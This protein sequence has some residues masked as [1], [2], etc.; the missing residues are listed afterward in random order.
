MNTARYCVNKECTGCRACVEIAGDNFEMNNQNLAFVKKQAE[1]K[2]EEEQCLNALNICPVNAIIKNEI[3]AEID[4]EP[5]LA[6]SN[7]K[8]TLDKYPALKSVLIELSPKFKKMQNPALYNTLARF[9]SFSD[10][11]KI[12]GVSI[13]EILHTMNKF[14]G[15]E[16]KLL[17]SMPGCIVDNNDE[18]TGEEITWKESANRYIYD[19]S[20]VNILVGKITKLQAQE[21]IVVFSV[22]KPRELLRLLTVLKYRFN[23]EHSREYRISI[24]KDKEVKQIDWGDKKDDFEKIDVREA[25]DN[26][27]DGI[28]EKSKEMKEGEGFVLI[29][30]FEPLPMIKML[31]KDGFEHLSEKKSEDEVW[32]YFYKKN[33]M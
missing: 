12:T 5:I 1:N 15:V 23:I 10:A 6:K 29:Q 2:T 16:K 30:K 7:I 18:L 27:F 26:P 17:K 31:T 33:K 28:I 8:E 9:A 3:E 22:E 14:L 13:C 19:S 25:A 24:F 21:N 4:I 32:V 20:S 11:A